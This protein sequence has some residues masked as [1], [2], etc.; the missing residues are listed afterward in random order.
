MCSIGR[1]HRPNFFRDFWVYT[2]RACGRRGRSCLLAEMA[3]ADIFI[4]YSKQ[5]RVLALKLSAWL[6]A[7]G[8]TTWQDKSVV[9]DDIR[10]E[11]IAELHK[12]RVVIVLWS[13]A[14]VGSVH[15]LQE[16]IAARD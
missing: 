11:N 12:A 8:W 10:D 5:D 7:Q 3:M 6:E 14:S 9:A 16:A 13:T 1:L 4:S 2:L 15:I